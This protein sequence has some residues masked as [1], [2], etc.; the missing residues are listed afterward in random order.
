MKYLNYIALSLILLLSGC[1]EWLDLTPQGQIVDEKLFEKEIGYKEILTGVYN[2]IT[3][4]PAYGTDLSV[5][6]VDALAQYW[7]ITSKDHALYDFANYNLKTDKA[8]KRLLASWS[9]LYEAIANLNIL[10]ERLEGQDTTSLETYNLLKGEALGLRAYLHF[11]L[12]RLFGPVLKTTPNGEAIPYRKEFSKN[13]LD[14]MPADEVMKNIETDLLEAYNLLQNDPIKQNG[15][16]KAGAAVNTITD[17]FRGIRMNYYAVTATLARYYL[18]KE[19]MPK[20]YQYAKEVIEAE[21]IFK[22]L[23]KNSLLKDKDLLFQSEL[24]FALYDRNIYYRLGP[25]FSQGP[26]KEDLKYTI[27]YALETNKVYENTVYVSNGHGSSEDYRLQ[28]WFTTLLGTETIAKYQC[29]NDKPEGE[30]PYYPL[31]PM[32]RLS[33]MYYIAAEAKL[34]TPE[35][36]S[37][38]RDLLNIVRKSRNV[39]LLDVSISETHDLLEEIIAEIRKDSWAEGKLFYAYKRLNHD[40]LT[41][42][43]PIPAGN[44][45]FVMPYPIAETDFGTH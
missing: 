39:P 7:T 35:G 41:S 8:E 29:D 2:T 10:L 45:V 40:I 43:T 30:R 31:I 18:L 26:K 19:D 21:D 3:K 14:R 36:N 20:A 33:E 4:Q 22:L 12:L 32:I 25:V 16:Q 6:Y 37:E 44:N 15:R 23:V 42:G 13:I 24:I 5:G 34:G 11:D 28:Y 38:A 1:N 17:N 27:D 9:T